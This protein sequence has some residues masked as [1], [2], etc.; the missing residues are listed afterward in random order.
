MKSGLPIKALAAAA[1]LAH[2]VTGHAL[3]WS[4]NQVSVQRG[5]RFAEP[6]TA[7]PIRKNVYEFVHNSGDKLGTN[8]VLGQILESDMNYPA[9][10]GGTGSQ[11]FYGLLRRTFSL[12][13]LS[14][15]EFKFGPVQDTSLAFVFER[16]TLNTQFAPGKRAFAAGLAFDLPVTHGFGVLNVYAYKERNYNGITATE[17]NFDTALMLHSAWSVPFTLGIPLTFAGDAKYITSKGKDGF[18]NGTKPEFRLHAELLTPVGKDTGLLVG[19][20]YELWRNKYGANQ[21]VVP[22]AKQNT[23]LL[24][25][26][27]HF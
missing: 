21:N 16:D 17:V 13:K 22:G 4:D 5:L 9:A 14:G 27:Y 10:G 11:E 12:S 25:A 15:R 20:G 3:E 1:L 26:R 7:Q 2:S 6:G 24:I 18:G 19:V 23:A 8:L